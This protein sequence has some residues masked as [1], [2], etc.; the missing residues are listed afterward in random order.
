MNRVDKVME[1]YNALK[2]NLEETGLVINNEKGVANLII[3]ALSESFG[4]GFE[5]GEISGRI[6]AIDNFKEVIDNLR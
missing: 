3:L 4:Q 5:E 1:I 6:K 2:N